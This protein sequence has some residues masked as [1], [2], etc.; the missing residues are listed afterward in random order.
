MPP[1]AVYCMV[2]PG[3]IC[4]RAA[5]ACQGSFRS[6]RYVPNLLWR[7]T[8]AARCMLLLEAAEGQSGGRA[9]GRAERSGARAGRM[10]AE[11]RGL[12]ACRQRRAVQRAQAPARGARLGQR[13]VRLQPCE[14]AGG[15]P[16]LDPL[17]RRAVL[18]HRGEQVR[19][20]AGRAH[21]ASQGLGPLGCARI[22]PSQCTALL[23]A[24]SHSE[25]NLQCHAEQ[26][27]G[28]SPG[29][30]RLLGVRGLEDCLCVGGAAPRLIRMRARGRRDG[31]AAR[32]QARPGLQQPRQRRRRAREVA[33]H[34]QQRA[35]CNQPCRRH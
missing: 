4:H 18:H 1:P 16:V 6:C 27:R 26:C 3:T 28:R 21:P 32:L 10:Q 30:A 14:P 35:P 15:Q 13:G 17:V 5:P 8:A 20:R 19:L 23:S 33:Q 12:A 25:L 7:L 29:P 24:A 2:L 11:A 31:E 34:L 22:P 9:D